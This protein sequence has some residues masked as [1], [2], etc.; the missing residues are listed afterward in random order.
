MIPGNRAMVVAFQIRMKLVPPLKLILQALP[1]K[2]ESRTFG[3]WLAECV[4]LYLIYGQIKVIVLGLSSGRITFI[5]NRPYIPDFSLLKHEI[6]KNNLIWI[7]WRKLLLLFR[8]RLFCIHFIHC[9]TIV[10]LLLHPGSEF[11]L[12][13]YNFLLVRRDF[14]KIIEFERIF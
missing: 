3:W 14:S 2:T 13:F 1:V 8:L 7:S 5:P 12:H 4:I 11:L 10:A 9:G 6:S